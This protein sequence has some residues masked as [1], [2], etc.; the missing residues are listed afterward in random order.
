MAAARVGDF[1]SQTL[2]VQ[3]A[4]RILIGRSVFQNEPGFEQDLL[5]EASFIRE[6][7]SLQ[8]SN[9][10]TRLEKRKTLEQL[11]FPG[12]WTFSE[13]WPEVS[14]LT[15]VQGLPKSFENIKI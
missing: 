10:V 6:E 9:L 5:S 14:I 8:K 3:K 4:S 11:N 15:R 2:G 1:N 13:C 7:K 12:K